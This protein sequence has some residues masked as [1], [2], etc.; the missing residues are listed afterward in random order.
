MIR[1]HIPHTYKEGMGRSDSDAWL[2]ACQDKLLSL[3]ETRTYVLVNVDEVD[4]DNVVGCCWVFTLKRGSDG[5]V[6]RYK[7]RIVA[8]GFSQAYLV[9][10]DKTFTPVIKWMSQLHF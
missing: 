10:Y 7:A 5:L 3:C 8:K 4:T 2:E 6:G 9:N 1:E